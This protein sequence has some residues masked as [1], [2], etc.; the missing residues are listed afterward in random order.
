M[1]GLQLGAAEA[2]AEP[3][4][5][6]PKALFLQTFQRQSVLAEHAMLIHNSG[7]SRH[8]LNT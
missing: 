3:Q 5:N 6:K 1:T 4:E 7:W 8:S 2:G